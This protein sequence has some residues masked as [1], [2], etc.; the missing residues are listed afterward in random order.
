V[1]AW[2]AWLIWLAVGLGTTVL[3][4]WVLRQYEGAK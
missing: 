2:Q 1:S 4:L 3:L